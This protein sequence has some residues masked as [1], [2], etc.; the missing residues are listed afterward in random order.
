MQS[1]DDH[2]ALEIRAKY[3]EFESA[4]DANSKALKEY[5]MAMRNSTV[6]D[7]NGRLCNLYSN[8]GFSASEKVRNKFHEL[9]ELE[10]KYGMRICSGRSKIYDYD[11]EEK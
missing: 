9:C 8:I 11:E 7:W 2:K 5:A 4:R 6:E 3:K 1:E 10:D